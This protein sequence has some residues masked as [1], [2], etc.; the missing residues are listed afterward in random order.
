LQTADARCCDFHRG[1]ALC[2]SAEAKNSGR[3]QPLEDLFSGKLE[4]TI[5]WGRW[6]AKSRATEA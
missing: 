1:D 2:N 6:G 4:A 5:D 3:Q